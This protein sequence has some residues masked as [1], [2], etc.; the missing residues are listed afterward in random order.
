MSVEAEWRL[1][2]EGDDLYDA[3]CED[4]AQARASVRMES[5]IFA[6]DEIGRRIA[7]ALSQQAGRGRQVRLRLDRVGSALELDAGLWR[8]MLESGVQLEWS[9]AWRWSAPWSFHRRNHRKLLIVDEAIAYLGGFNI[10]AKP[11]RRLSGEARWRDTH[12]R[13][14]GPAVGEAVELF[15]SGSS[16]S[17]HREPV[18]PFWLLPSGSRQC[19]RILR[20]E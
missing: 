18:G 3:M 6:S 4:I 9:R 15:D 20:C 12:V 2:T 7:R 11:S 16:A 13:F 10:H 17:C 19:Q 1:F 5:Y 14:T 8:E